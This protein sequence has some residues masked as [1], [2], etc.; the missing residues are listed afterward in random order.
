MT[1]R[2]ISPLVALL[3]RVAYERLR[4]GPDTIQERPTPA[5]AVAEPR[6]QAHSPR[7]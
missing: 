2:T 4:A 5:P 7:P 6:R 3:A 1:Q